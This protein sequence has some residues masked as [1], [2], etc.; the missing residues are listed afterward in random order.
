MNTLIDKLALDA[1]KI[2]IIAVVFMAIDHIYQMFGPMGAPIWLTWLGRPVMVLFLF[3]MT[4]SFE[5]TGNRRKLMTRLLIAA[6]FMVICNNLL[7]Y[8]LLPNGDINLINSAFFTMFIA[9]LYMLFWEI[10]VE[11]V[12][13]KQVGKVVGGVLLCILP[14]ITVFPVI[15]IANLSTLPFGLHLTLFT[16]VKMLPCV[17]LVEGGYMM[18]GLGVMMY[19]VR[20]WRWAQ[21]GVLAATSLAVFVF[22]DSQVAQWLMVFAAIPILLYNKEKGRGMKYFFYIFYPAHVYLLY[23]IATLWK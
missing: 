16:L 22:F 10:I 4:V 20:R 17:L 12:R 5:H 19:I 23:V 15:W 7:Q 6:W 11:G 9:G 14:V 8:W 3:A 21:V 13:A 18:V 1:T 2:K